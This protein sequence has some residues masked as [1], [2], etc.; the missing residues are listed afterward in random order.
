MKEAPGLMNAKAFTPGADLNRNSELSG[1]AT[2][3]GFG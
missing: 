2:S 3:D 1:H